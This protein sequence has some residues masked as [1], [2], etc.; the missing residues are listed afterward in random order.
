MTDED[1]LWLIELVERELR[2]AS[3]AQV[4]ALMC[5]DRAAMLTVLEPAQ[6]RW[7]R[8]WDVLRVLRLEYQRRV[9]GQAEA[10]E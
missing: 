2:Q 6:E 5:T 3:D 8:A 10:D 1:L 7:R 9:D 4:P